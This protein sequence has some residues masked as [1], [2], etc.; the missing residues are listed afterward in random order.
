ME[1]ER[2]LEVEREL[3]RQEAEK[4]RQIEMEKQKLRE[5]QAHKQQET[6]RTAQRHQ[7]HK[8]LNFQ[9]QALDEKQN[10]TDGEITKCREKIKEITGEID[11]MREQRDEKMKRIAELQTANQ[12]LSV[13]AQELAHQLL[14]LQSANKDISTRKVSL[15]LILFEFFL[16][17]DGN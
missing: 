13:Q 1:E 5:L 12:H 8:T 11:G 4:Q 3:V 2:R 14:Q 6:E 10:D 7:R 15:L 17:L 16:I 9:L